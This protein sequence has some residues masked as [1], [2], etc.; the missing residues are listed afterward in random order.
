MKAEDT[1][2]ST[3]AARR[4][5]GNTLLCGPGFIGSFF[6]PFTSSVYCKETGVKSFQLVLKILLLLKASSDVSSSFAPKAVL[7]VCI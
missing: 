2:V 5:T 3:V 1:E 4:F 6:L 7:Q